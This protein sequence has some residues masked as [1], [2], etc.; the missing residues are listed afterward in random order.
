MFSSIVVGTDGSSTSRTAV[1]RA[2]ELAQ[3]TGATLHVVRGYKTAS[4]TTAAMSMEAMVVAA[5]TDTEIAAAVE[6]E[7]AMLADL[8]GRS[9]LVVKTYACA[10]QNAA[11]AILDVAAHQGADL[12]IVGN[13]GL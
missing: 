3:L 4:A 13:K 6:S 2:Q 9:D 5:P 12:V 11:R 1:Q 10:T 7:L 8:I